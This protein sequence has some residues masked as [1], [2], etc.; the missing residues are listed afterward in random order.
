[1]KW[2]KLVLYMIGNYTINRQ[3]N[4]WCDIPSSILNPFPWL[5]G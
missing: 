5:Y 2:E 3:N 4:V 1:M